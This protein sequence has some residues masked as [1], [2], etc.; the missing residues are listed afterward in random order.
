MKV[1][2]TLNGVRRTVQAEPGE[3]LQSL[4]QR[5][6][7]PS[8][9][10]SD[11][12]EGFAGSDTILL[13]GK[14]VLAG[15]MVA[16][17]AEGHCIETVESLAENGGLSA[18]QAAMLDAGA[19]QSAYNSPAAA[20]L[21]EELLRRIEAPT[22]DDV[23]DA[24]SGLYSRSTGYVQF[25]RAVEI[26]RVRRR[27]ARHTPREYRREAGYSQS[28]RR[29][30]AVS[31]TGAGPQTT[32][33]VA[34][35][36]FGDGLRIVG[37]S[38]RRVDGIKL[39]RGMKAYVE[40]MVE[41]GCFVLKTLRSPH[42]HAYI[43]EIDTEEAETLP[44]V[45]AVFTW[46]NTPDTL[47]PTA[48]QGFPEPS[49]YD[50]RL[51]DRKVRY[52]G[53]RVAAVVAEDE[54][55]AEEALALIMVDYEVLPPVLT[56]DDAIAARGPAVHGG[57]ALLA[58]GAPASPKTSSPKATTV[59]AADP[60]E[61]P[62]LYQ[63]SIGADPAK[64]L[65]ASV[66]GGVGDVE[67]GLREADV[68]IERTYRTSKVSCTPLEPHSVYAHMDG[69]R[70]IVHASTQVPWHLRRILSRVI[71]IGENRIRVIKERVG[72]CYGAK[73]DILME[74]LCAYA[75]FATGR[76]VRS[77]YTRE[78]EF[79]AAST[80]HPMRFTVEMG[81]R[82]DGKL[83]AIKLLNEADTGAYG[84]H[85]LTVPMNACSKS[86][87]MLPCENAS[88]E[89]RSYYTNMTPSGA[90]QGYGAPQG[91]FAV[92][93]AAAELAAEL[94]M[95]F[96][97]FLR[98][99]MVKEGDLLEILKS[100]GEGRAGAAVRVRSCGLDRALE[101]GARMMEWG[102]RAE[103][104]DPDLKIG[105]GVAVI[106]QGSGLPGLDQ[107]C[108][109]VKLLS[110]GTFLV[111]SGGADL[112]TGLDTVLAKVAAERLCV[113]LDRVTVLSG[114]TDTTPFDKGAYASSGTF[115]SGNAVLK[116]AENLSNKILDTAAAMLK[117][118]REGLTLR[119]PGLVEAKDAPLSFAEIAH[120]CH[121][122][123]G[124]GELLGSASYTTEDA[125]FPYAAHFCWL[126]VNARTGA[127][128][129]QKYYA[130][131]DCGTPI[132][133][134]LAEGQVYGAVLKS[135]G[136]A[137]YEELLYDSSGQCLNPRLA[138]YGAPMIQ[139]LPRDV[140]VRFIVT[141]DP[142]GPFGGKSVSEISMNGAAPAVAI[143][144]HD[145][146]GVW[147]RDWPITPEKILKALGRL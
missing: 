84:N 83:T 33:S 88:F 26:A 140:Q 59:A 32:E 49:P 57:P 116:A 101:E 5:M 4:L 27:E 102:T 29:R 61:S 71:G 8:V 146:V 37:K 131:T 78:E 93:T 135:I 53:D 80:R 133:P 47:Y 128:T 121:G 118:P 25:F 40:D 17:Q 125:A 65:A 120:Y 97:D 112:G 54:S 145:A 38:H 28:V 67:K 86:L 98:K 14:A 95:D 55:V 35:L 127:V 73:Q 81:A 90:Y 122:G 51:I 142:F 110:D 60:R 41:A 75:S 13:D 119:H 39:V 62:V 31:P 50:R 134:E 22:E 126:A 129:V 87:P 16:G 115:F 63:F 108:A 143:A 100:L 6:G 44:G 23:R 132:N 18:I 11:D 21:L 138:A 36:E 12:G 109:D 58:S 124:P 89:V 105:K 77:K 1:S 94:G 48:G 20:L 72:G 92:Q 136:H 10:D 139:E 3:N 114:D 117:Q 74:E 46:K 66:S 42:A 45:A 15:L 79:I 69:D 34:A 2:F 123:E 56:L 43:R 76:P 103:S 107:A 104:P 85:C 9:R 70:L 52:V 111:R 106:Q 96:A 68:R 99:N 24:L 141:K 147:I 82:K 64:N 137:L 19:V 91:S 30:A 130:L 7:I 113:D 144:V